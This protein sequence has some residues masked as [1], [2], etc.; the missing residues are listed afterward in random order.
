MPKKKIIDAWGFSC[1]GYEVDADNNVTKIWCKTCRE[2]YEGKDSS[3]HKKGIAKLGSETYVKG[4]K[5]IKKNNF[6]DHVKSSVV[7]KTAVL[8]LAKQANVNSLGVTD[9]NPDKQAGPTRAP[10]QTTLLPR[11]QKLNAIQRMQLTRK[12]QIAHYT[13][14]NAKSS[15]FYESL[16]K[17][18]KETL[19]VNVG[20]GYLNNKAAAEMVSFLSKSIRVKSITEPIN[21]GEIRYYSVFN[22][23]S[24]SAKN[25]NEKELFLMKSAPTGTPSFSVM[26]LE[27]PQETNAQGLK[28]AMDNSIKKMKIKT[29]RSQKEIGMCTDGAPVNIAMHRLVKD[30][31][32]EHYLLILCPNHKV[33]LAVHDGFNV[34]AMN[35]ECEKDLSDIYYLFK[36]ANLRW[37]LFKRQAIF[38]GISYEQCK[39][40]T[41]TRWV[42]HQAR[43]LQSHLKNLPVLIGFCNQQI[44]SP[45][46]KSMKDIVPKLMGIKNTLANTAKAIFFAAK[47]NVLLMLQPMTKVLQKAE[48][49]APELISSCGKALKN[50][51]KLSTLLEQEGSEA[52]KRDQLFPNTAKLIKDLNVEVSQIVPERQTRQSAD[53]NEPGTHNYVLLHDYLL[54]GNLDNAIDK[55][56]SELLQIVCQLKV[57]LSARLSSVVEDPLFKAMAM[58]LD[59][60]SY[61][62]HE[63][64]DIVREVNIIVNWFKIL[65]EANGCIVAQIEEELETVIDH[66]KQFM[67]RNA[68]SK[69]WPYLF[70]RQ[71]ELCITNILHVAEISLSIPLSK[72]ETERVFFVP[73]ASF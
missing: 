66:V 17:F 3:A 41:G 45:H 27:E 19:S 60:P 25:M 5:T 32:G 18:S 38:Q 30:E 1:L 21:S 42:E 12:M 7:H 43:A 4:T 23:G 16:V 39:P 37:R 47:L 40:P 10:K 26:S 67:P 70:S 64:G 9:P 35:N 2:F 53:A 44:S 48:L 51:T 31:I 73:L 52:L 62:F 14:V 29:P 49:L 22:D 68:A 56:G 46:N 63:F 15:C 72:A 13:A 55:V 33:E 24:S 61:Q 8:R 54:K 50:M 36:R 69:V 20:S 58:F 71:N 57:R 34:S 6:T 59:T 65:L 28:E 11:I